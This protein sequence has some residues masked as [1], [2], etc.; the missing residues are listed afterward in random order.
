MWKI[1]SLQAIETQLEAACFRKGYRCANV[2]CTFVTEV[3]PD[4]Y[5]FLK[6]H[7]SRLDDKTNK[8]TLPGSTYR[9]F[10]IISSLE[11]RVKRRAMLKVMGYFLMSFGLCL[12]FAITLNSVCV[13]DDGV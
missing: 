3:F 2:I 8:A 7:E 1:W 12:I 4:Q 13:I 11:M 6:S 10:I 5:N 9:V